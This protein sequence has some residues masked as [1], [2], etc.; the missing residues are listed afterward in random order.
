MAKQCRV[1]KKKTANK[2]EEDKTFVAG[3]TASSQLMDPDVW[4]VDSGASMH[5]TN[6]NDWMYDVRSP[7]IATIT[8]ASKTPLPVKSM[9]SVN[10]ILKGRRIQVRDVLYVP[11]L[12]ANLLSVSAMVKSGCQVNFRHDG[13]DI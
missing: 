8:G 7:A 3:F 13:C 11:K 10:L 5:M 12:A 6:R 4:Y 2:S 9:G 1:S